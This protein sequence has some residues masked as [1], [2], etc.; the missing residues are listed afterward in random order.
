MIA[1]AMRNGF[2]YVVLPAHR[3][4]EELKQAIES[5]GAVRALLSGSGSTV[6]GLAQS[7]DEADAVASKLA[8]LGS[9][10]RVVRTLERGVFVAPIA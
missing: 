8:G 6:F 2:E 3:S 1:K 4:L 5:G 10:V 9:V 7:R